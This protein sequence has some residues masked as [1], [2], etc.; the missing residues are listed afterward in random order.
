MRK[1][2]LGALLLG[3]GLA[4]AAGPASALQVVVTSIDKNGDGTAT[5]HFAV[6]TGAGETLMPG[7]DFVTVY[8]FGGLVDGSARTPGGWSFSSETT[9]RTPTWNGYPAV[10]P[11]DVPDPGLS[12]LTWTASRAIPGGATI[13]GFSA[14]T[15]TTGT[16]DG[17]YTAQ[18]TVHAGGKAS[19][20]AVIGQLATPAII[21]Q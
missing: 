20:Q 16:T 14:T 17:E 18:L 3:C 2:L 12:N 1:T 13:D 5:Y 19:K 6:K 11:V 15:H 9:G 7:A 10:L 8:N 21:S 4:I